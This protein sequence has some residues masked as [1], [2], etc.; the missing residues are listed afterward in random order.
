MWF[1]LII[2]I[3]LGRGPL[4]S[5]LYSGFFSWSNK[6]LSSLKTVS[7]AYKGKKCRNWP[8][9]GCLIIEFQTMS[10]SH[11]LQQYSFEHLHCA[12]HC[13]KHRIHRWTKRA[14][15]WPLTGWIQ[16][17]CS[18]AKDQ[19]WILQLRLQIPSTSCLVNLHI[20]SGQSWHLEIITQASRI[21]C[22]EPWG[23]GAEVR[24][25]HPG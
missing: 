9:S 15:Y 4:S 3:V 20:L 14:K 18:S 25:W 12:G 8:W 19:K 23:P 7:P 17:R 6:D 2:F 24:C 21:G 10:L 1:S 13:P 5:L 11:S 16:D 22:L